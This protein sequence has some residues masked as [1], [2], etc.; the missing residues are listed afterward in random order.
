MRHKNDEYPTSTAS[1]H[2]L[3][4]AVVEFT[5]TWE[6]G[7]PKRI[8]MVTVVSGDHSLIVSVGDWTVIVPIETARVIR[9]VLQGS[10]WL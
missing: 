4:G 2:P 10:V 6:R 8:G 1:P 9:T 5:N 7:W 3:L